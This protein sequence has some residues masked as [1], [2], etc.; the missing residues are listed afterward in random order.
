VITE[1][2][3]RAMILRPAELLASVGA[4]RHLGWGIALDD[5]AL[6]R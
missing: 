1:I 3:E 4:I 6:P 5:V 2:T